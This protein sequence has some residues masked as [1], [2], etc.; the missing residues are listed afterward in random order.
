MGTK[1]WHVYT[2][3]LHHLAPRGFVAQLVEHHRCGCVVALYVHVYTLLHNE[4]RGLH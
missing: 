1:N 3:P 4:A 2:L